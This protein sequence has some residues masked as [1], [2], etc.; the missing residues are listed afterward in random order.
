MRAGRRKKRGARRRELPAKPELGGC[1]AS[2]PIGGPCSSR[3]QRTV[4]GGSML[5]LSC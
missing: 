2:R 5:A 3:A 4:A 1:D